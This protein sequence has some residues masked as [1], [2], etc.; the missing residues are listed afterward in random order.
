MRQVHVNDF[1]RLTQSLPELSLQRGEVGVVR[2]TWFAPSAV[3]EV[4]F[5]HLGQD[6]EM[7]ALLDAQQIE[8]EDGPL[9][10]ERRQLMAAE[11]QI[12]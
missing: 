12:A 2:S 9:F 11:T 8:L 1:V 7:R 4:E 3:F 5:H 6:V 10:D